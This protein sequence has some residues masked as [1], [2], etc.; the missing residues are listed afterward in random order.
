MP[1]IFDQTATKEELEF[2]QNKFTCRYVHLDD[3]HMDFDGKFLHFEGMNY[4]QSQTVRGIVDMERGTMKLMQFLRYDNLESI[5]FEK[6]IAPLFS[7]FNNLLLTSEPIFDFSFNTQIITT[8]GGLNL[9]YAFLPDSPMPKR[10]PYG[11]PLFYADL[12]VTDPNSI[13]SMSEEEI[14]KT[15]TFDYDSNSVTIEFDLNEPFSNIFA[16][17]YEP[18]YDDDYGNGDDEYYEEIPGY[19]LL[20]IIGIIGFVSIVLITIKGKSKVKF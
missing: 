13:N 16:L 7:G 4:T 1:Y 6:N 9:L 19:D 2:M 12:M 14:N 20:I 17:G 5:M 10:I 3:F 11:D 8:S 18:K 15:V